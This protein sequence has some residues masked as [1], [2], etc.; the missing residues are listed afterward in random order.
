MAARLLLIVVV[1]APGGALAQGPS[2]ATELTFTG[3]IALPAIANLIGATKFDHLIIDNASGLL[4]VSTKE[5]NTVAVVSTLTRTFVA[6]FAPATGY[7]L[8]QG[9]ELVPSLGLLLVAGGTGDNALHA[10]SSAAPFAEVWRVNLPEDA[11]NVLYDAA[12]GWAWVA[13]GGDSVPGA[14]AIIQIT[15]TGGTLLGNITFPA[16]S[17][18]VPTHPE[19]FHFAGA[20]ALLY[21]SAPGA[22]DG[23]DIVVINRYSR[24]VVTTWPL[25]PTSDAPFASELDEVHSRFFV[26]TQSATSPSFVVLNLLDGSP[27]FSLPIGAGC[28]GM[29]YDAPGGLIYM[30]VGG[31]TAASAVFVVRQDSADNYT[32]VGT[33]PLPAGLTNLTLARTSFWQQSTRTLFV[34]VPFAPGQVPPQASQVLTWQRTSPDVDGGGA[35]AATG[36]PVSTLVGSVVGAA[37]GGAVLAGLVAWRRARAGNG[38]GGGRQPESKPLL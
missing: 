22:A 31:G 7:F 18:G 30:S 34:A 21:A 8:P 2:V 10:F 29:S 16:D 14:L 13:Y 19:E 23:G 25:R 36:V 35:A 20:S 27:V 12:T 33:A 24:Q 26:C 32:L 5:N 15:P 1:C 28:D 38:G 6:S 9:L 37:I 4:F 3:A 11:D 17:T